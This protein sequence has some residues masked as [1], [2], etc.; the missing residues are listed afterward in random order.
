M[1]PLELSPAQQVRI[2]SIAPDPD[3][4]RRSITPEDLAPLVL[5]IRAQG[6]IHPVL[7][8]RHPVRAVWK[9]TPYML[10]SGERRWTAA[11]RAGLQQIPATLVERA[12]TPAERLMVQLEENDGVLRRELSLVDRVD[13]VQRAY[14][15]SGMRKMDFAAAHGR[16]APWL[17]HHLALAKGD[18][19]TRAALAE[20]YLTGMKTA[21]FF[22]RLDG[23]DREELLA[24]A[25]RNLLPITARLIEG[26]AQRHEREPAREPGAR[27]P[28]LPEG[29]SSAER[30][31]AGRG[32]GAGARGNDAGAGA[33][34][35]TEA[36]A[37]V[38]GSA[39]ERRA[40]GPA[41]R[42]ARAF[43]FNFSLRQLE[44]LMGLLGEEPGPTPEELLLQLES[45]LE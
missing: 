39:A 9:E 2:G 22:L 29:A 12:L 14:Q 18:E 25:R 13:A 28:R 31:D 44:N 30:R 41:G 5:S 4:P 38:P 21:L 1:A 17:S 8:S 7:V 26:M 34:A 10:V 33:G 11:S 40:P 16:T 43:A 35:E 23:A 19:A 6:V 42:D 15:L 27:P 20:G 45:L 24:R 37:V 3:Q 32:A 36:G